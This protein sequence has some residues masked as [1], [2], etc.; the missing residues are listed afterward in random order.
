MIAQLLLSVVFSA[1]ASAASPAPGVAVST[2]A[3]A[4]ADAA[5][6][7]AVAAANQRFA[8]RCAQEPM[9]VDQLLN[10]AAFRSDM[11]YAAGEERL[12]LADYAACRTL[13]GAFSG[14]ALLENPGRSAAGSA[15]RCQTTVAEDRF[16]FMVL[17]GGDSIPACRSMLALDNRTGPAVDRE[18][19]ALTAMVRAEGPA[20]SCESIKRARIG[21]PESCEDTRVSWSGSAQDC[22]AFFKDATGKRFCR[23]R[24]A[25]VAG[26]RNPAQCAA[27]PFCQALA[28]KWPGACDPLRAKFSRSLCGRVAKDLAAEKNRLA[29]EQQLLIQRAKE[30]SD[31]QAAAAA[32][33]RAKAE[34]ALARS[35]AE[36]A[37][38]EEK[39]AR[40][41]AAEAAKKAAA[42]AAVKAKADIEAKKAAEA[43]A[44]VEKKGKPQFRKGEPMQRE[45]PEVLELMKAVE[46]G[47]PIPQPK[48]KPK[49]T[50]VPADE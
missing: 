48:P 34:A 49:P 22:D 27:S 3:A 4:P 39:V 1:A 42:E 10:D 6:N 38:A 2:S 16:A 47:R 41:A 33:L 28:T 23:A 40:K 9:P 36:A 18:C 14:C 11:E 50:P 15:E 25:L 45:S 17:R 8:A 19:A 35:K 46:E 12:D 30:K 26:L 21:P 29:K 5:A 7:A 31:A 20:L 32:A 37:A 13:Q 44:K 24:A 43:K